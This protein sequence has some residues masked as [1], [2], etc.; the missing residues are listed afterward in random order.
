MSQ[1]DVINI[2][3]PGVKTITITEGPGDKGH[4]FKAQ[5]DDAELLRGLLAMQHTIEEIAGDESASVED[6]LLRF[7][8]FSET[9]AELID[10]VLGKGAFVKLFGERHLPIFRVMQLVTALANMAG[11]AYDAMFAGYTKN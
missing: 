2:A 6:R 10:G 8:E 5:F 7:V 9:A 3:Q 1:K 4:K 11:P